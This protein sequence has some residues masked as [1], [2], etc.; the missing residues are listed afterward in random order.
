MPKLSDQSYLLNDQYRTTANLNKRIAIHNRFSTNPYGWFRWVFDQFDLPARCCLLEVGVGVG[1]LWRQNFCRLPQ[2]WQVFLSDFSGGMVR[3]ARENLMGM[4][5]AFCFARIDVQDL[6]FDDDSFDAVVANHILP[7][8]PDRRKALAQ[9]CRVLR[10]GGKLYATTIGDKHLAEILDLVGQFDLKLFQVHAEDPIE[11]TLENG[12]AQLLDLFPDVRL[13]RYIGSLC[14]TEAG[15]LADYILSSARLGVAKNMRDILVDFL[16]RELARNNG[17]IW[18]SKDSG[19]FV[20][21][22]P[23][24]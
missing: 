9:I 7:H 3:Q 24:G 15:P 6:P 19:I 18:I 13:D 16:N 4:R 11:F 14:V 23:V 17:A 20:A 2:G 22:K 10:P 5:Q 8:V 12:F 1:D 21:H